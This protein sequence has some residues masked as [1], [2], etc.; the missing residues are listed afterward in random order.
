MNS[1]IAPSSAGGPTL[2]SIQPVNPGPRLRT[3]DVEFVEICKDYAGGTGP[4]VT[5]DVAVDIGN[6]GS[7]NQTFQVSLAAGEC[8]DVWLHGGLVYDRVVVTEVVPTGYTASVVVSTIVGSTTTTGASV[9]SNTASVLA[10]GNTGGLIVF[11]N[12]P[13]P[14]TGG[15]QGCTP[16]YWKAPQHADSWP[17]PYTPSTLFSAVFENAFPNKT[18]D[19]VLGTGGGGLNALGRNTVAALLN[20]ASSGV[21]FDL[22]PTDVINQFNAA[23]PGGNYEQLKNTFAGLNE[24]GC[25]LD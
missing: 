10:R 25:P 11:T 22:S 19:Q 18:L 15:G 5:V 3:A 7:T 21:S 23:Y 16:G 14:T 12:R 13:I 8:E 20:A 6:D 1:S 9:S 24:Q 4:A 2:A 17:S